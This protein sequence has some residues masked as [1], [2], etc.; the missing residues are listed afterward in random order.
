[1]EAVKVELT[2]AD[3]RLADIFALGLAAIDLL[4]QLEGGTTKAEVALGG[5]TLH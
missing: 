4:Q 1:M 2:R 5:G 3:L